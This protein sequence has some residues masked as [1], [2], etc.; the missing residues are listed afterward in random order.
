M[1]RTIQGIVL[2]AALTSCSSDHAVEH[3]VFAHVTLG[4]GEPSYVRMYR[5]SLVVWASRT[6]RVLSDGGLESIDLPSQTPTFSVVVDVSVLSTGGESGPGTLTARLDVGDGAPVQTT[7]EA[8]SGA[9]A[10]ARVDVTC[11][12]GWEPCLR[13]TRLTVER[14][15]ELEGEVELDVVVTARSDYSVGRQEDYGEL[16]S[17]YEVEIP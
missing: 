7:L 15:A 6:Y 10:T 1:R 11:P 5:T 4:E 13:E 9:T 16:I 14:S 2:A 17:L 12:Q 3:S 8:S